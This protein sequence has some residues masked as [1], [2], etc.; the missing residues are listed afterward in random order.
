VVRWLTQKRHLIHKKR[1]VLKLEEAHTLHI[2]TVKL[3]IKFQMLAGLDGCYV[4]LK[5]GFKTPE[6][7]K[8]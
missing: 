4:C 3:V 7:F 1:G 8:N 2:W 5:N 6:N